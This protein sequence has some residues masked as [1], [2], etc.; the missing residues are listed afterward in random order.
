MSGLRTLNINL[1]FHGRREW[2]E[3]TV[4]QVDVL[5]LISVLEPLKEVFASEVF[6]V[7]LSCEV[8]E[9]VWYTV[10]DAP[11]KMKVEEQVVRPGD[12]ELDMYELRQFNVPGKELDIKYWGLDGI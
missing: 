12:L 9:V 6:E 4:T 3:G 10:K 5:T 8:P 11:F 2:T 7:T 1:I